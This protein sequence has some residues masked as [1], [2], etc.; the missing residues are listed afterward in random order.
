MEMPCPKAAADSLKKTLGIEKEDATNLM[1]AAVALL[2]EAMNGNINA[3][4]TLMEYGGYAP[5]QK[6]RDEERQARINA[7]KETGRAGAI[8]S[9]DSDAEGGGG[10][11]II[12]LP[13]VESDEEEPDDEESEGKSEPVSQEDS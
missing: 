8:V 5:D 7:I 6:L 2:Q 4:N 1:S 11:V 3:F 9:G 13:E 10:D 12:Y